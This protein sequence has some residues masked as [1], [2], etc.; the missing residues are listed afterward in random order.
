MTRASPRS[1]VR[2]SVSTS[3]PPEHAVVLSIDE[4]S[5]R[6]MRRRSWLNRASEGLD[7]DHVS[8]TAWTRSIDV[9]RLLRRVVIRWW[10]NGERGGTTSRMPDLSW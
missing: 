3:N 7:N 8:A 4:K 2:S 5:L 6:L 1:C 10:R 9:W